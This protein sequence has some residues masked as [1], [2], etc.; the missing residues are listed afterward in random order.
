MVPLKPHFL[1]L[2]PPPHPLLASSQRCLRSSGKHNDLTNVGHT[3]RHH[4]FFEMLG[5]FAFPPLSSTPHALHLAYTFLTTTLRIPPSRLLITH[6]HSDTTTP[7]L[8]RTTT[9]WPPDTASARIQPRGDADNLWAMGD[10]GPRG[11]CTEVYVDMGEG[12]EGGEEGRWLEVWNLVLMTEERLADGSTRPLSL[13]VD[14]GMGLE[15][16]AAVVQGVGSNY[17][18]DLFQPLVQATRDL[19]LTSSS[20]SPSSSPS[21]ASTL[22]PPLSPSSLD[23]LRHGWRFTP[24]HPLSSSFTVILD[25]LRAVSFLYLDG[26]L[27]S[28]THRGYVLRRILRRCLTHAYTLG[29][30][31]PFLHTLYPALELAMADAYPELTAR[32][33]EVMALMKEEEVLFYAT[34]ER[35]LRALEGEVERG[36]RRGGAVRQLSGE[37]AFSLYDSCG[38]PLDLTEMIIA[39][40]GWTVDAARFD[41]LMAEQKETG[42]AAWV[43]S[44]DGHT[45]REVQ[46]WAGEE[47]TNAFTGYE[48]VEEGEVE[49]KAVAH[50]DAATFAVIDPSPFYATGG[51]QVADQGWL[52]ASDGERWEVAECIRLA[53]S[54]SV[55]RL[56]PSPSLT[57]GLRCSASVNATLRRATAA[58]H[59]ST[60]LLHAALRQHL[61]GAGRQVQ[62]A[63]SLV[64]PERFRFDFSWPSP[65]PLPTLRL[66]ESTVNAHALSSLPVTPTS[67]SKAQADAE[68]ALALF[69]DKY[70]STVRVVCVGDGVSAELCGGTHAS[71]TRECYPFVILSEGSVSAGIRR[72]EGVSGQAAVRA[73]QEGWDT[74]R[75]VGGAGIKVPSDTLARVQRVR[76]ELD[77]ARDAVK[78]LRKQL[79]GKKEWRTSSLSFDS[80]LGPV[81]LTLHHVPVVDAG[82]MAELS[83]DARA[84]VQSGGGGGGGGVHV[85]VCVESGMCVVSGKGEMMVEEVWGRLMEGLKGKG[86]KGGGSGG[87]MQGRLPSNDQGRVDLADITTLLLTPSPFRIR[88]PVYISERR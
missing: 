56:P 23:F 8:W 70:G 74:L 36:E 63:G 71:N 58:H 76:E 73:L 49:V 82:S 22:L 15:R 5:N 38:F 30:R 21:R 13:C 83:A 7:H 64:S 39:G 79:V 80:S 72:I 52:Q 42:R 45:P 10:T 86:G 87:L 41:R 44:G 24:N 34:L 47:M 32:K 14:T 37:V 75:S 59:T 84:L 85:L 61:Q 60:H 31:T 69:S 66:L 57:P 19:I 16:M 1:S 25:H 35:G 17:D 6:H 11:Y 2:H 20:S 18:I 4:T 77:A 68:G 78:Q 50:T 26:L 27:P 88:T 53:D 43:G 12:R 65:I 46:R 40:K 9:Q 3:P 48:R 55:L 81:P 67:M 28:N 62:Q 33:R 29:L 51:G 54:L